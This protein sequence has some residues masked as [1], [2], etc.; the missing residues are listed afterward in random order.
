MLKIAHRGAS[1]YK[2]ENTLS[3]FTAAVK[4]GVDIV[5]LDIRRCKTGEA[6]VIHDKFINS[7]NIKIKKLSLKELQHIHL[8]GNEKIPTLQEALAVIPTSVKVDIDIK[9]AKATMEVIYAIEDAVKKGRSYNDF[10]VTTYNPTILFTINRHNNR[11]GTSFLI[12][13][14][15]TTFIRLAARFHNTVSVQLK[16]KHVSQQTLTLAH[17]FGLQVWAWVANEPEEIKRLKQ[18]K[19]D[20]IITDFPDRI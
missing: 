13:F 18:M 12:F 19:V 5:E 2:V 15:P 7:K 14:L 20:G 6:I 16:L 1:G 4:L 11:I 10:L 9:D 17:Q 8:A 3:A